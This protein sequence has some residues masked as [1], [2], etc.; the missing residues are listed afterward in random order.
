MRDPRRGPGPCATENAIDRVRADPRSSTCSVRSTSARNVRVPGLYALLRLDTVRGVHRKEK[1]ATHTVHS[2]AEEIA[3]RSE[4]T[5]PRTS[6]EATAMARERAP[7][8]LCLLW[9]SREPPGARRVLPRGQA[10]LVSRSAQAESTGS[11]VESFRTDTG[12]LPLARTSDHS[13][14]GGS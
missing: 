10:P 11:D 9:A 1:D 4:A 5:T 2:E 7:W 8:A 13:L 3:E 12:A 14:P 6:G